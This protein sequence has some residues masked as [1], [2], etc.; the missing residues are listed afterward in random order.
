MNKVVKYILAG[1]GAAAAAGVGVSMVKA[2][3]TYKA[4]P[5][6]EVDKLP[7]EEVDVERFINNLSKAI[8][9]PTIANVDEFISYS[10]ILSPFLDISYTPRLCRKKQ[11]YVDKIKKI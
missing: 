6:A 10:F 9:Y 11:N 7:P 2:A 5:V 4:K 8:Q 3:A 1:A